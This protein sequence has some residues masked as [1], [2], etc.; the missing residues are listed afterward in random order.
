MPK[1]LYVYAV[2]RVHSHEAGL[3]SG[4]D[5]EQLVAAK[6]AD[7]VFKLLAEKN[8]GSSEAATNSS[9]ALIAYET[10]KTWDFIAE[11]AG[12]ITPFNVFRYA[13]DYHN[14][15]A[16][17]KLAYTGEKDANPEDYFLPF[18]TVETDKILAAA[19]EHDFST[20]PEEMAETGRKAYEVLAHTGNGQG[21]DMVIDRASLIAVDKA[22][23]SSESA[24]LKRYAE[25]TCDCANIRSA[26]RCCQMRK[27]QDFIERAIAPA[28]TLN[29]EAL[30]LAASQNPEAIYEYLASTSYSGAVEALKTSTA[31]FERWCDDEMMDMIRP[32]RNNYFTIE[33]LAAFILA[34]ENEIRMVRLVLSAK[35]NGIGNDVLRERLRKMYV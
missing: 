11:L 17:I 32:Q 30:V 35:T 34:R 14:L 10:K 31:A 24:L 13:N 20:L 1:E 16:A 23:K 28:G 21:C 2:T 26:V 29:T 33:P 9:D 15:K 5:M 19:K 25:L 27:P 6:N 22:G 4:Q 7:E 12:D 18:G 8:W 3:L